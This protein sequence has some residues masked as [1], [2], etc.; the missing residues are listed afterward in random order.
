MDLDDRVLQRLKSGDLAALETTYRL[1]GDRLLRLSRH[2]LGCE[3]DA[4][5]AM[6]EV[7]L[8]VFERAHQFDGRSRF[9]TWLYRLAINHCLNRLERERRRSG[10]PLQAGDQESPVDAAPSPLELA[11]ERES[12]ERLERLLAR[13]SDEH[14]AVLVLREIES[15]SYEEIAAAL[16]IPVGTVMSRLARARA[17]LVELVGKNS[18]PRSLHKVAP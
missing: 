2:L 14:R 3:A 17:R 18:S 4:E 10:E 9:S 11:H 16:E 6:Q 13:L 8:K 5:D 12:K 15:L 1:F 7:F